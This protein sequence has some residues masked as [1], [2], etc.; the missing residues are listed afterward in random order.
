[1]KSGDGMRED[2]GRGDNEERERVTEERLPP[3]RGSTGETR[4]PRSHRRRPHTVV[5]SLGIEINVLKMFSHS[6]YAIAHR[7]QYHSQKLL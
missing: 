1:M 4:D 3:V 6:V 2:R 5:C 7:S